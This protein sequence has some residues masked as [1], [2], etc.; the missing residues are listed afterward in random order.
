M[1]LFLLVLISILDLNG[2]NKNDKKT[3]KD[4]AFRLAL[5]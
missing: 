4:L 3:E 2:T 1:Y 5:N